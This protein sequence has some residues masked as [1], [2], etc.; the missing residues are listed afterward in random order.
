ML[1]ICTFATLIHAHLS[2]VPSP[3]AL[4]Y[5]LCITLL[6]SLVLYLIKA[7]LTYTTCCASVHQL[8]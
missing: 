7:V 3:A 6:R 2:S 1:Q 8:T 5:R 4:A